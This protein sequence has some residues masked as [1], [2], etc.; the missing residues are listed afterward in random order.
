MGFSYA[1]YLRLRFGDSMSS[2]LNTF[3]VM[4]LISMATVAMGPRPWYPQRLLSAASGLEDL[5]PVSV[6]TFSE[7]HLAPP[8]VLR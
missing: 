8:A 6:L 7:I 4:E 1:S 2:S 5:E 3:F